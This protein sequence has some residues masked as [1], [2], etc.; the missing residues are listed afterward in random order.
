MPRTTQSLPPKLEAVLIRL[1]RTVN[2]NV[3]QA[4]KL[5]YLVDVVARYVL[6]V[7]ITEGTH[8]AWENGVVTSE[9]WHHFDKCEE[10]PVCHLE[11][12]PFSEERRVVIDAE[13]QESALTPEERRVV[14]FVAEEYGLTRATHLGRM[15][16]I[17]NPH[18]LKWG[19]N[20]E[21]DTGADAYDRM[22]EDYQEMA[23]AVASITLDH[24]R[25]H[26]NP[27]EDIEDAIA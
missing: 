2:L 26:S 11:P 1:G 25:R 8:E 21:A 23:Q 16:K 14:D 7:P 15:T 24:L 19:N 20:R 17:M 22:S 27:V 13:E 6:G 10:S 4:V 18:I 12:V 5:P 9:I 3:T